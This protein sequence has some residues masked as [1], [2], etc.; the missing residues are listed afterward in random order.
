MPE[1]GS[2]KLAGIELL[3]GLDAEELAGLERLCRY[4][5]YR[6]HQQIFERK[7]NSRDVYFLVSGR[8]RVVNYSFMG[9]GITLDELDQGSYF[10]ELAAIDG[11]PRSARVI[12]LVD[13]L[14]ASLPPA[15]F[16]RVIEEHPK[17]ALELMKKLAGIVRASNE[18]IMELSTLGAN[19]RV[20]A[21]LLREARPSSEG[22]N[23]AVIDPLPIHDDIASLVST[24][25]ETVA[26]VLND[27]AR[28]GIVERRKDVLMIH[29]L[30]RLRS[31]VEEVRGE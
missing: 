26:R 20:H 4:K 28:K 2:N 17:M 7:S 24:T 27:L 3:S 15:H 31:M 9:R 6:P 5:R 23:V 8:V 21:E 14:V 13:S 19:N 22:D 18:R 1:T 29:D 12:S 30:E 10:G 25:R 16:L 11:Q